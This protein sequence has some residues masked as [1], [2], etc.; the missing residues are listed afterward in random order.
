MIYNLLSNLLSWY[1]IIKKSQIA[2]LQ[3]SLR[4]PD[5]I[6]ISLF[7]N[8]IYGIFFLPAAPCFHRHHQ[9]MRQTYNSLSLIFGRLVMD[10]DFIRAIRFR[11]FNL[12]PADLQPVVK[13][14]FR[15]IDGLILIQGP[16]A[17]LPSLDRDNKTAAL[18]AGKPCKE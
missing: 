18:L 4:D 9:L 6:I 12:P 11:H 8:G 5:I 14:I 16:A 7:G 15:Y 2:P 10:A 13:T 17:V 1:L 3:D